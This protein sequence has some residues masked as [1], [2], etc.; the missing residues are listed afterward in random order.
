MLLAAAAATAVA[1]YGFPQ[2]EGNIR[3]PVMLVDVALAVSLI[4]VALT[5]DRL[6]PLLAAALQLI[7]AAGHPALDLAE[8]PVPLAYLIVI[9]MSGYLIPPVLACGTFL[10]QRRMARTLP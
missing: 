1:G 3:W 2:P 7:T 10:H 5:A 4:W 9:F 6:W 8:T